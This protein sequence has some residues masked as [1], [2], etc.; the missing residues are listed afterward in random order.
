MTRVVLAALALALPLA[1]STS[2]APRASC[3]RDGR[4]GAVAYLRAASL[5][6]VDLGTCRSKVVVP[7]GAQAPV[8]WSPNGR[9]ILFGGSRVV[10]ATGGSP[11]RPLGGRVTGLT[12]SSKG[13]QLAGITASGGVVVGR[14]GGSPRRLLP[15][16]WG[17]TAVRFD[18]DGGF[19]AVSR[20]VLGRRGN[21]GVTPLRQE[22]WVVNVANK[23]RFTLYRVPRGVAPPQL[24]GWSPDG[25][26]VLWWSRLQRSNS[27][28]ADGRP[29]KAAPAGREGRLVTVVPRMLL[30]EDFLTS[31]GKRLVLTAGG[32]RSTTSGK[33]LLSVAIP[34][35]RAKNLAPNLAYSWVSPACSAD[36][37]QIAVAAGRTGEPRF[38]RER[39]SLWV[40]AVDGS[41][42][43][44]V[45]RSRAPYTYELPRWSR[46]SHTLL[47]V[48]SG[49]TNANANARGALFTL[50]IGAAPVGPIADLGTSGN[51]Y[52]HYAWADQLDW[53][54]PPTG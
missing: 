49:P 28:D 10:A 23:R 19:L 5:R 21:A 42:R 22:I 7:R 8:R 20:T 6:V 9:W 17:A 39:R 53:Y 27:L 40:V 1:G 3:P 34:T 15:D 16:G 26:W 33:Q 44:V 35:W 54:R 38:G 30:Y 29:L 43:R 41:T 4:L 14:P 46:D 2:A 24:V 25:L 12:W 47:F 45:A 31:C 51:Y 37:S 13:D 50:R 18:P 36:G 52:G 48:R 32:I 11:V